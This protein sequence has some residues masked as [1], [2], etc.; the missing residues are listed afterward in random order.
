MLLRELHAHPLPLVRQ[1]A[2][3]LLLGNL[4]LHAQCRRLLPAQHRRVP[5]ELAWLGLG[6]GLGFGAGFGVGSG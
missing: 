2:L 6:F 3:A 4:Q 1:V 5:V